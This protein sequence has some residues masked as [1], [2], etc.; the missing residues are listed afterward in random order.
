[1][2]KLRSDAV[3][4]SHESSRA[5]PASAVASAQRAGVVGAVYEACVGPAF[6]A[7]GLDGV[8]RRYISY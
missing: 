7:N 3:A 5:Q 4:R 2:D 8:L 1:L 6:K